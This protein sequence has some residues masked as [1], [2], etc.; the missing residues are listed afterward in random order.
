VPL[1]EAELKAQTG[2]D[3]GRSTVAILPTVR[4]QGRQ[5]RGSLEAGSVLRAVCAAFPAGQDPAVC[6]EPWV[7]EDECVEGGEGWRDCNTG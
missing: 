6:R 4:I 1:L 5:Y 3:S 2:D 7:S